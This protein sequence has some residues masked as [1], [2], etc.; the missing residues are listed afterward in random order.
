[1][2][3]RNFFNAVIQR[4]LGQKSRYNKCKSKRALCLESISQMKIV[5]L[6]RSHLTVS[7]KFTSVGT[8]TSPQKGPFKDISDLHVNKAKFFFS[9]S[10]LLDCQQQFTVITPSVKCFVGFP[11]WCL[12]FYSCTSCSF[13]NFL[14]GPP[15]L[16]FQILACCRMLY[17]SPSSLYN[18]LLT[19]SG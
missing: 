6:T 10:I 14:A 11:L 8:S 18:Q 3:S 13:W 19:P 2:L 1:M 16:D 5:A 12:V 7:P 9:V 4:L 17:W 15:L